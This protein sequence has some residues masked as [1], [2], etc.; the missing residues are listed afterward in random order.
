MGRRRSR[1][2]M[3]EFCIMRMFKMGKFGSECWA[4]WVLIV[5]QV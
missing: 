4:V 5:P 2:G 1:V 3:R